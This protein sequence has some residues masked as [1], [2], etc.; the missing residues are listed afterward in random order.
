MTSPEPPGAGTG[1]SSRT[2][3]PEVVEVDQPFDEDGLYAMRATVA[4]HVASLGAGP[5]LVEQ[6]LIVASELATNAIRHGGGTGRL[7]VWLERARLHLEISD[8]GPG[9]ADP[10]AGRKLPD[11]MATEGRGLWICRQLVSDLRI[12]TGPR[13]TTVTAV[14]GL[15][16][17]P[18]LPGQRAGGA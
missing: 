6:L 3:V 14:V 11:Q 9:I 5:V 16:G 7:R 13:G 15:D 12:A 10:T 4:A 17:A 2:G 1:R 18:P 8:R